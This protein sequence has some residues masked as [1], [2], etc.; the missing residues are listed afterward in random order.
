MNICLTRKQQAVIYRYIT[1]RLFTISFFA[2]ILSFFIVLQSCGWT[3]SPPN[4][5]KPNSGIPNKKPPTETKPTNTNPNNQGN[6]TTQPV[7]PDDP[8]KTN[9]GKSDTYRMA[10]VLPFLSNQFS[11]LSNEVPEKSQT[12]LQYYG[13]IQLAFKVLSESKGYPNLVVDVIDA[14]ASDA[15][16]TL[17]MN[18]SR[19]SKAQIIFG[20]LRGG[21]V[22][23]L[24]ERTKTTNQILISPETPTSELTT[25][26][27]GFIQ[28]KPSLKAHCSRIIQ[29]VCA[30]KKMTG[31]QV[32]L[33]CK[34]KEADR[35][36]YFRDAAKAIGKTPPKEIIVPDNATNFDKVD[37]KK[38]MKP[39]QTTVFIMPSWA[40]QD[41]ILAFLSRLKM[42]KGSNKVEVY[43]MPQW[44]DYEQIEPDMLT[45]LNVHITSAAYIDRSRADV[46]NFEQQFYEIFGTIPNED[47]FNGYDVT[48]LTAELLRRY[49]LSFPEK[50]SLSSTLMPSLSGGF[51][52]RRV[53]NTDAPVVD[54][55]A[56]ATYEYVEN[57]FVHILKFQN[58]RY[59]PP[60]E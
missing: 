10:V 6:P 48:M 24:A 32:V 58:F 25:Q 34:Q 37:L 33:V 7:N 16:F 13:G 44:A 21:Q 49:G 50:S 54:T 41:W 30:E 17:A 4:P 11:T 23:A 14:Q 57:I 12:A 2:S 55:E 39:G 8:A 53:Q 56:S 35:L 42:T 47:A 59:A 1:M 51:Y 15:E 60:E 20:P 26:N 27:P 40:G 22:A 36:Q 46:K 18:N 29:Y 52:L 28:T 31:D 19:L 5:V 45:S 38:M 9:P 43:G 3:K